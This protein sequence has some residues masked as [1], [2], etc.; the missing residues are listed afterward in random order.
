MKGSLELFKDSRQLGEV[1]SV[2][3][4]SAQSAYA[5][6]QATG[7]GKGRKEAAQQSWSRWLLVV[8]SSPNP[9]Q[10]FFSLSGAAGGS[11]RVEAVFPGLHCDAH[12]R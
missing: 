3:G 12:Q 9:G 2:H 7:S 11:N 1:G 5:I 4:L 6:F 10:I 8:H